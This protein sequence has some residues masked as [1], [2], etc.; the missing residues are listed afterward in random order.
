MPKNAT[1]ASAQIAAALEER[2]VEC[3]DRAPV[4]LRQAELAEEFGTSHIP[5]REA[6]AALAKEGLVDLLPNRGAVIPPLTSAR[7]DELAQMRAAL[8]LLALSRA[9]P[10]IRPEDVAR[11]AAALD[12]GRRARTLKDRSRAN[13]AFHRALYAPAGMPFLLGELERLWRHADRY[14]RFTWR[15]AG[16][17][18]RSDEE[19]AR[20]LQAWRDGELAL[21]RRLARQHIEDAAQAAAGLLDRG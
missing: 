9:V 16:Y 21:A 18:S 4:P 15:R 19:H 2:I 17:E 11:A 13:W 3:F 14:L 12:A 5:V 1:P 6:L 8:E 20:L 10:R 7:G